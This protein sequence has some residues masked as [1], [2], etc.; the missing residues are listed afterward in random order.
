MKLR[1]VGGTTIVAWDGTDAIIR[2]DFTSIDN[3]DQ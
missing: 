3:E 1:A 2:W